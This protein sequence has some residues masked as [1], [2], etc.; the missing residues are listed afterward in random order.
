M[1]FVLNFKGMVCVDF[2]NRWFGVSSGWKAPVLLVLHW[3]KSV[4]FFLSQW[5]QRV[6]SAFKKL[7]QGLMTHQQVLLSGASDGAVRCW[8]M[9]PN[10]TSF[11]WRSAEAQYPEG[12]RFMLPVSPSSATAMLL[13]LYVI[14]PKGSEM[15]KTHFS[16]DIWYF[17]IF[18]SRPG[19]T[20]PTPIFHRFKTP[21]VVV[22]FEEVPTSSPKAFLEASQL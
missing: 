8:Q 18:P 7:F 19:H 12:C 2:G 3:W 9:N 22:F 4:F 17:A 10:T 15:N 20:K 1:Y 11:E 21:S 13:L 5:D 16:K 6:F 14:L